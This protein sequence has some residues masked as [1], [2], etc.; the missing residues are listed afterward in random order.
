[1]FVFNFYS[2]LHFSNVNDFQ[3]F[4]N[5]TLFRNVAL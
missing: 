2:K 5:E 3:N 1:M 4:V